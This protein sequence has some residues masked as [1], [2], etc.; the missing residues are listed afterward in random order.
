MNSS[1]CTNRNVD[2]YAKAIIVALATEPPKK[3]GA[4]FKMFAEDLYQREVQKHYYSC[5]EQLTT[6]TVC[7]YSLRK[8]ILAERLGIAK[9]S[10]SGCS[11]NAPE[12]IYS[13]KMFFRSL[14]RRNRPTFPSLKR[15]IQ[16]R[17]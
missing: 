2:V 7:L 15:C 3:L 1:I 8:E 11:K 10:W 16:T 14:P 5:I 4:I 12:M 6:R 17:T 9:N 13:S